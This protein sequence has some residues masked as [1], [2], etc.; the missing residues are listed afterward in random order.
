MHVRVTTIQLQP[1]KVDE[2]IRIYQESVI[3]A[4]RQQAGFQSTT[5]LVDR[6]ANKGAVLGERAGVHRW[7][8]LTHASQTFTRE[9]A[10]NHHAA[11]GG[12]A[13]PRRPADDDRLARDDAGHALALGHRVGVHHPR[14]RLLVGPHV[15]RG[16]V[17]VGADH[18]D[19]LGGVAAGEVLALL[20]RELPRVAAHPALGT[21]VRQTHQRALPG[22]QHGQGGDFA[23]AHL[24]VVAEATLRRSKDRIMVYAVTCEY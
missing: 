24:G 9:I 11:S 17:E 8:H 22:H 4:A 3:P 6:A 14:H 7:K 16:N 20:K 5:L 10:Q 18:Q 12:L 15:R 21:A 2:A 13:P 1:G 23:Q 19:D